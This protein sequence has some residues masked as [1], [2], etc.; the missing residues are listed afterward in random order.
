[1]PDRVD[2]L[3]DPMHPSGLQSPGQTASAD[4]SQ[5]ELRG[6]HDPVLP[7]R[8]GGDHKIGRCAFLPHTVKKAHRPPILPP[9]AAA[10]PD[11]EA[12]PPN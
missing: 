1:M 3:M 2:A 10:R 12:W 7:S 4:A 5:S 11:Q 8:D 9:P 6:G